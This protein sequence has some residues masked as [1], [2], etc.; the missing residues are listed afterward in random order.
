MPSGPYALFVLRERRAL[1]TLR[2]EKIGEDIGLVRGL[3][4]GAAASES[5]KEELAENLE[6]KRLAF[7]VGVTAIVLSVW[8]R[9]GKL[10]L[11]K[12][13]EMFLDKEKRAPVEGLLVKRDFFCFIK[14]LFALRIL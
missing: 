4:G 9:G 8:K 3:I 6:P 1:R 5:S 14:E 10:D 11:Q 13:V 7:S 2:T 12:L